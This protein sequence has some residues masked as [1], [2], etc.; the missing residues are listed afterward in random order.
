MPTFK[1]IFNFFKNNI[2]QVPR[3]VLEKQNSEFPEAINIDWTISEIYYEAVFY[4]NDTECI[5]RY[6]NRGKL[7]E[8]KKNLWP[9][10]VP[11][12]ISTACKTHGEVMNAIEIVRDENHL[13][14]II[15]REKDLSR[16][17]ILFNQEGILLNKIPIEN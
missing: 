9:D 12:V 7:M 10:Q 2:N 16:Y 6:S 8:F 14:E 11:G 17:E 3:K 15:V 1:M 4:Q 5:A 13:F